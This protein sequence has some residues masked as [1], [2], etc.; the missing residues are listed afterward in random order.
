MRSLRPSKE[1]WRLESRSLDTK[2]RNPLTRVRGSIKKKEGRE[3][4][5]R[6]QL[7]KKRKHKTAPWSLSVWGGRADWLG[8]L[9]RVD[10]W[11]YT[12]PATSALAPTGKLPSSSCPHSTQTDSCGLQTPLGPPALNPAALMA[13]GAALWPPSL[14]ERTP[15]S[16]N[17][18]RKG[19]RDRGRGPLFKSG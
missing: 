3:A 10:C 17:C 9:G 11:G 6:W 2:T 16:W 13:T 7:K 8:I 1:R 12:R 14:Q 19:L 15:P 18:Q 4:L 5:N